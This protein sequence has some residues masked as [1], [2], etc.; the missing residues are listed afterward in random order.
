MRDVKN[1]LTKRTAKT[2]YWNNIFPERK[3]RGLSP[4]LYIRI[5]VSD[6]YIPLIGLSILLHENSGTDRGNI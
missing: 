6:L 5:S 3:L 4:N 1:L 2:E